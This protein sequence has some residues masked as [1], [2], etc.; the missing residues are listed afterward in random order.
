MKPATTDSLSCADTAVH[1]VGSPESVLQASAALITSSHWCRFGKARAETILQDATLSHAERT[2]ALQQAREA[3]EAELRAKGMFRLEVG[4][5]LPASLWQD[6]DLFRSDRAFSHITHQGEVFVVL[7][8]ANFVLTMLYRRAL[9]Q[10][11]LHGISYACLAL[12]SIPFWCI[13]VLMD[14]I[15]LELV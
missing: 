2:A 14:Q 11:T 7:Q 10:P 8:L 15:P 3:L 13:R 6:A 1:H 4:P 9:M 12:Q 5:V